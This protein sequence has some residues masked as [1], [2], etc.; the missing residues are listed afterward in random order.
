[1]NIIECILRITQSTQKVSYFEYKTFFLIF[2]ILLKSCGRTV[3]GDNNSIRRHGIQ[4]SGA[5]DRPVVVVPLLRRR[6]AR[7]G[8]TRHHRTHSKD[9]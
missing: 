8:P 9:P 2:I 6:N 7:V 5:V 3:P 4:H 1:M